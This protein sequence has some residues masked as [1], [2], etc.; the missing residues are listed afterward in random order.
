MFVQFL[1]A[2]SPVGDWFAAQLRRQA[3]EER[4]DPRRKA[5]SGPAGEPLVDER[6][7]RTLPIT[8]QLPADHR[9][10]AGGQLW[11]RRDIPFVLE[12]MGRVPTQY[13]TR[14]V[15]VRRAADEVD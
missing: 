5:G 3:V 6:Y 1:D 14:D 7:A 10:L 4:M 15:E 13:A 9:F 8:G 12:E 11:A 2:A